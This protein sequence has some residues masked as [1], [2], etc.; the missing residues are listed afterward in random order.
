VET[1][2]SMHDRGL[3]GHRISGRVVVL[4]GQIQDIVDSSARYRARAV[5]TKIDRLIHQLHEFRLLEIRKELGQLLQ[6]RV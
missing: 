1:T 4:S 5:H 3:R 2:G 6:K